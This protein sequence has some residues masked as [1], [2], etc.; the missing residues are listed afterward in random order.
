LRCNARRVRRARVRIALTFFAAA[1]ARCAVAPPA[2]S[3]LV[4]DP[5][6]GA[7]VGKTPAPRS[8]GGGSDP[9]FRFVRVN[10]VQFTASDDDAPWYYIGT[11]YWAGMSLGAAGPTGNR[12]RL[13]RDLDTLL[14]AGVT[15]LRVLGAAEGPDSEP[16]RI[17]PSLMPCPGVYNGDVLDGFDFLIAEMGARRMR[18][19]VVMGDEWAWSGGH[20]QYVRWAQ[21]AEQSGG[22][23]PNASACV[24]MGIDAASGQPRQPDITS[25][26]WRSRGFQNIPY[27]GPGGNSWSDY[28][29][30]A[31][32]FYNSSIAQRI[33]RDHITF[34]TSRVNP[35]T[36]IAHKDDPT[37]M[38]WQLA[39]EPRAA[40]PTSAQAA[41]QY[42]Q[43]LKDAS[44]F[45]KA[46]APRQLVS[47][48]MGTQRCAGCVRAAALVRCCAHSADA[49]RCCSLRVA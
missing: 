25:A 47:T 18:A 17:V 31:G 7:V 39:N 6:S 37:I 4:A 24:P 8:Y 38:S 34:L 42:F 43:W 22:A 44:Q 28:Q 27:P 16:W 14:A 33:W 13:R 36:G 15:Q 11:N 45:V 29:K 2:P 10:G 49:S 40:D 41:Q 19:T 20:A 9:A 23:V 3:R 48:G 12:T 26:A 1:T 35:Y 21:Q 32:E 5:A 30:L 46:A